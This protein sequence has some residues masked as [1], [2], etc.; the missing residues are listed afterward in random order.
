MLIS[1][2]DHAWIIVLGSVLGVFLIGT[3]VMVMMLYHR[4]CV[5]S[6]YKQ[7][8]WPETDLEHYDGE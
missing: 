1:G 6:K 7:F 2:L 5:R 3:V 8:D 4:N